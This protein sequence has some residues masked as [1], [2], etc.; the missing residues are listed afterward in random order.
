MPGRLEEADPDDL[1][2]AR[3]DA[4][5][6]AGVVALRLQEVAADRG[7]A[8]T[9]RSA[10]STPVEVRP[11]II[12]RLIMRQAARRLPARDDARAALERRAER[13]GEADGDLRREVDVDEPRDAVAC[14]R[15]A[16]TPRDSQIRLSCTCAPDSTSL[17]G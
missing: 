3:A 7:R 16:T 17:Y 1:G 13:G 5:V 8:S 14:R 12:A 2:V 6:E 15:A 10:T 11:E 4:D 9:R